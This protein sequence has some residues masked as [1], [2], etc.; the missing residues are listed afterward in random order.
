[1]IVT[2]LIIM[3]ICLRKYFY[4]LSGIQAFQKDKPA[5][6]PKLQLSG[7]HEYLR[8]P[9]Y[10]WNTTFCMWHILLFPLLSNS[11]APYTLSIMYLW[12]Q[13]RRSKVI[14]GIWRGVCAIL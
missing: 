11:I 14:Y 8:H 13:I 5:A 12:Y 10:F 9:L 1:L 6:N 4:E 2:G 3:I 7:L